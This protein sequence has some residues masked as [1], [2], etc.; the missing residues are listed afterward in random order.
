MNESE[1]D[2]KITII[3]LISGRGEE[4]FCKVMVDPMTE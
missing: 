1:P 2:F 3:F 4:L